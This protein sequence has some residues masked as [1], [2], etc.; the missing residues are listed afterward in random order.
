MPA[1]WPKAMK[2]RWKNR[3]RPRRTRPT[4]EGGSI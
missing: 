3:K 1:A 2:R 4:A